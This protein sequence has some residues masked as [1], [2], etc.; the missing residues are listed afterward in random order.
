M[1]SK[2]YS[3]NGWRE[4]IKIIYR[5]LAKKTVLCYMAFFTSVLA[6]TFLYRGNLYVFPFRNHNSKVMLA[7]WLQLGTNLRRKLRYCSCRVSAVL[8]MMFWN[9]SR[10]KAHVL[11]LLTAVKAT[12]RPSE[13]GTWSRFWPFNKKLVNLCPWLVNTKGATAVFNS[14]GKLV[15]W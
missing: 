8:L 13:I 6:I 2:K 10:S 5:T 11:T 1:S 15:D 7:S 9:T 3:L 4:S 12:S 14:R